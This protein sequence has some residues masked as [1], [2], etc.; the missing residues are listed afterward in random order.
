M[1]CRACGEDMVKTPD[2]LCFACYLSWWGWSVDAGIE[3]RRWE[4]FGWQE[5]ADWA[6][7]S[8][9]VAFDQWLAAG[10]PQ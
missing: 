5:E 8:V 10:G 1:K 4:G 3:I 7:P 6:R 2:E 9:Q